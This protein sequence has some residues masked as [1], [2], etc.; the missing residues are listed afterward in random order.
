[1][2]EY[3]IL[4]DTHLGAKRQGGT[5]PETQRALR[6]FLQESLEEILNQDY[7]NRDLIIAGDLFDSF[8][9]D[10]FDV[11]KVYHTLSTWLQAHDKWLFLVAGNH[12]WSPRG[13]AL[14]SFHFLAILL[15]SRFPSRVRRSDK[16]LFSLDIDDSV[17]VI[18]HMPNQDLFDRE[19]GKAVE[20]KPKILILHANCTNHFAVGA[21]HSL[22]VSLEQ[23][24]ALNDAGVRV[25]FA[26]EHHK[27]EAEGDT[28]VLGN[29]FP[30]SIIDCLHPARASA[31]YAHLINSD[32]SIEA[33]PTWDAE[34]GYIEIPWEEIGDYTGSHRFVRVV[35]EAAQVE[36]ESVINAIARF[37]KDNEAALVIG[38]GVQIEGCASMGGME[39]VS[40]EQ[41]KAYDVLGSLLA[42]LEPAEREVVN[43][44]LEE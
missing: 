38:N 35:G 33:V 8:S 31:K 43:K 9:V 15:E 36:A 26:H 11:L 14:S 17:A 24:H 32:G 5:T 4:N 41:I 16:G 1:M 29:P 42:E 19:I 12:D 39:S 6:S 44:M 25:L 13:E 27:R 2:K 34:S 30:S 3:L 7:A 23:L 40:I 37:R 21:D 22:N 20:S 10:I 28:L 18:P